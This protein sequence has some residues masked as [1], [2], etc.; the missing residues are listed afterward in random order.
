MIRMRSQDTILSRLT[1]NHMYHDSGAAALMVA[2]TNRKNFICYRRHLRSLKEKLMNIHV[3]NLSLDCTE[4][5]LRAL[6]ESCGAVESVEI[7]TNR[8]THEPLG[9]G[10]VIMPSDE[11]GE[12]A[13]A[14]LNGKLL[15]GKMIT[16]TKANRPGGRRK[17]FAKRPHHP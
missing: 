2:L 9:Y 6:F 3:G 17:L 11:A 1:H 7:I 14:A 15:K 8:R 13:I 16:V 5:E 4:P 10:F 12:G